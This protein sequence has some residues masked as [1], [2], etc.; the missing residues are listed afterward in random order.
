M[1]I[2]MAA[3]EAVGEEE[4]MPQYTAN[5]RYMRTSEQQRQAQEVATVFTSPARA[6]VVSR[7]SERKAAMLC[8][9]KQR[10]SGVAVAE[11]YLPPSGAATRNRGHAAAGM[12][13]HVC[14][15]EANPH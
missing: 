15:S 5:R 9:A 13:K 6:G 11:E 7:R 1:A 8:H 2:G 10:K 12:V 14:E 3:A 4:I